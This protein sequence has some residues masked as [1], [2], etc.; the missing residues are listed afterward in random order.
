MARKND[1]GTVAF[2]PL[3]RACGT[4]LGLSP[5]ERKLREDLINGI[6]TS[7]EK[8]QRCSQAPSS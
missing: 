6:H 4:W 7:W 2:S 3:R 1:E 5:A 8:V